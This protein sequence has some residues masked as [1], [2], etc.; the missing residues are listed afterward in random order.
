MYRDES[1]LECDIAPAKDTVGGEHAHIPSPKG[2]LHM[3]AYNHGSGRITP[4]TAAGPSN[5][6]TSSLMYQIH[7]HTHRGGVLHSHAIGPAELEL[8]P[9]GTNVI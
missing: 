1:A 2:R 4:A 6:W 7:T 9:T 5:L 8:A 3:G